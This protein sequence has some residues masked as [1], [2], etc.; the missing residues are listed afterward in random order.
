M[1]NLFIILLIANIFVVNVIKAQTAPV[2]VNDTIF[3]FFDNQVNINR[4]FI[5]Q[6]DTTKGGGLLK[7]DT[8]FYNGL[9]VVSNVV[10]NSIGI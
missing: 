5:I 4:T 7:V 2:A 3:S 9:G 1:K 6:N 10:K 8:I